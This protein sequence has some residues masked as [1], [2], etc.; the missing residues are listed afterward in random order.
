V[1]T[2]RL[3]LVHSTLVKEHFQLDTSS[4]IILSATT[5]MTDERMS[6][7]SGTGDDRGHGGF[8]FGSGSTS[9][10][11][12]AHPERDAAITAAIA[13]ASAAATDTA[14]VTRAIADIVASGNAT[15]ATM[16]AA[17]TA[18]SAAAA[19]A[20]AAVATM[21]SA[22]GAGFGAAGAGSGTRAGV[23]VGGGGGGG[24]AV[25]KAGTQSVN[26]LQGIKVVIAGRNMPDSFTLSQLGEFGA[27]YA[28]VNNLTPR[29]RVFV[30]I[31][32]YHKRTNSQARRDVK[33]RQRLL[34]YHSRAGGNAS[35]AGASGAS[36]NKGANHAGLLPFA[37]GMNPHGHS[38]WGGLKKKSAIDQVLE[39]EDDDEGE[40]SGDMSTQAHKKADTRKLEAALEKIWGKSAPGDDD[41]DIDPSN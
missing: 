35:S 13:A 32:H 19:A 1:K 36:S 27:S 41:T 7:P 4:L 9:S 22:G 25:E 18:A 16:S 10:V 12:V 33:T 28:A 29:D 3:L 17:S 23:V 14:N 24:A 2:N 8:S 30:Q 31:Q 39:E 5:T 11:N 38:P 34:E 21:D 26:P 20:A 40:P 15:E 6:A 37:G